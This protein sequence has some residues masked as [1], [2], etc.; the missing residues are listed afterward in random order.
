[1]IFIIND[2]FGDGICCNYGS[3]FYFVMVDGMIVVLG[4]SFGYFELINIG[5]L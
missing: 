5:C 1:M 4:G 2:V 3:G